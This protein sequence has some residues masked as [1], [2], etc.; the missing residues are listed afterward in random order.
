MAAND[1]VTKE[2]EGM[3]TARVHLDEAF[4]AYRAQLVRAQ[5]KYPMGNPVHTA[6]GSTIK[7]V[8]AAHRF[9][10]DKLA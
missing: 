10:V 7:E 5:N 3:D 4:K 2:V 1:K 9:C 8:D 6:Y